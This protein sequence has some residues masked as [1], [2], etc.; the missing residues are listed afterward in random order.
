MDALGKGATDG[1][2]L[3]ANIGAMLIAFI[4]ILSMVNY[5]LDY[6][7]L[8]NNIYN[9]ILFDHLELCKRTLL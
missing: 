1:L 7:F 4:S 2:K 6:V 3:A 8:I 5:T 9:C